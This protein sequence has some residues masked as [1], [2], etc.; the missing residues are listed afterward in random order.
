MAFVDVEDR[1]VDRERLIVE[2]ERRENYADSIKGNLHLFAQQAVYPESHPYHR[3]GIG[4]EADILAST[5]ADVKAFREHYYSPDNA[6]LVLVGDF[7][8]ARTASLI[9][10]YFG[11]LPPHGTTPNVAVAPVT[12]AAT[13]H[14]R[15]EADS[16]RATV[17]MAWPLPAPTTEGYLEAE[18]ALRFIAG[19]WRVTSWRR[20]TRQ[21]RSTSTSRPGAAVRWGWSWW[22]LQVPSRW[23]LRS[24]TT[25]PT[26]DDRFTTP[27][28][29]S[30]G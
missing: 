8:S 27:R 9:E 20:R 15:V 2:Q 1:F 11:S 6:T 22:S 28:G 23:K 18:T 4:T 25:S 17:V 16:R 29:R 14:M 7:D 13:K 24:Q 10:H 3:P 30:A 12:R 21:Q 19:S 26:R 5:S